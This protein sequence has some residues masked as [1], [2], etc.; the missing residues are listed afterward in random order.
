[1]SQ[2]M[3][4]KYYAHNTYNDGTEVFTIDTL[5]FQDTELEISL[6]I[7][8][9]SVYVYTPSNKNDLQVSLPDTFNPDSYETEVKNGIITVEWN[10]EE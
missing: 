1:M 8:D 4:K 5:V 7:E 9:N 6:N 10:T 3:K 2:E